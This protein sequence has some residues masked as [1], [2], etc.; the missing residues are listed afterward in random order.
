MDREVLAI[1]KGENCPRRMVICEYC[2]LPLPAIN[3]L[4]HQVGSSIIYGK[5]SI[6]FG[7]NAFY[8]MSAGSMWKSDKV[9]L[10]VQPIC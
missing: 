3:L 6:Y 7:L 1:H 10:F 4:E 8:A 5:L 2:E 9:M